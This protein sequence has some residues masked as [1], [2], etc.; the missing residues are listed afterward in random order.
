[1]GLRGDTLRLGLLPPLRG[2]RLAWPAPRAWDSP[3]PALPPY[4]VQTPHTWSPAYGGYHKD[5]SSPR[6]AQGAPE[7]SSP[8]AGSRKPRG[9]PEEPQQLQRSPEL[10]ETP[11]GPR[12]A[13]EEPQSSSPEQQPRAAAQRSPRAAQRSP[14][15]AAQSSLR[16]LTRNPNQRIHCRQFRAKKPAMRA[17]TRN[18]SQRSHC[19]HFKI[20]RQKTI[21]SNR[22]WAQGGPTTKDTV[23]A[24]PQIP[25]DD[26]FG[27]NFET[28]GPPSPEAN[29]DVLLAARGAQQ[30]KGSFWE[31][32]FHGMK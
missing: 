24:H 9:A 32:S 2:G 29:Q 23:W 14:R 12:A 11:E 3:N 5:L 30:Q 28:F 21:S 6:A 1:M 25:R 7:Q 18:P 16:A 13:P 31:P 26:W 20:T 17:S 10:P 15:A 27:T 4:D 19:R 22:I 8:R